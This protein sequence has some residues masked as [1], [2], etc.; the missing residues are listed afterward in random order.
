MIR[1]SRAATG[2]ALAAFLILAC[3]DAP[4]A[5][6][7]S[8]DVAPSLSLAPDTIAELPGPAE[9]ISAWTDIHF[10]DGRHGGEPLAEFKVGMEYFGNRALMTTSY[11]ITGE[12]YSPVRDRIV[13]TQDTYYIPWLRKRFEQIYGIPTNKNCGLLIE[14][15][16]EHQAWWF[17]FFR[18]LVNPESSRVFRH[19]LGTPLQIEP[20]EPEAPPMGGGGEGEGG[21]GGGWVTVETCHY[22]A[23]YVNRVL[24]SIELRYCEY[25]TIPIADE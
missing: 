22:W 19:T 9:I 16:T 4:V 23:H 20:C 5:P 18:G 15:R 3:R 11:S 13:N 24:V 21:S 7:V 17:V 25:D 8:A 10:Y 2:A 14:A 12:G 1:Q 6:D